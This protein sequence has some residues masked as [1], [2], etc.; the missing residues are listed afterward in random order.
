MKSFS[1]GKYISQGTFKSFQPD[2]INKQWNIEDME[3]IGLLSQADREL[4]RL[5]M[6]SE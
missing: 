3:L 6:Y 1:A 4:G 5:D 2:K